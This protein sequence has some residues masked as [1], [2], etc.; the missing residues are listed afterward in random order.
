MTSLPVIIIL[1]VVVL[2]AGKLVAVY[3][4]LVGRR[5]GVDNAFAT[6][7]VQ[8][9]QRCD[10][11]PRVVASV[12]GY[13]Q[14]ERDVL[15]QLTALRARAVTEGLDPAARLALDAEMGGL[16]THV[17]ARAEAYPDLKAADTVLMLQRT[18]NEIEAQIAAARRAYNAAVTDYNTGRESFPVNLLAGAFGFSRRTLFEATA[19]ERLPSDTSAVTSVRP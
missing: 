3:N 18:L 6:I 1:V 8:L 15:E 14:Y 13:M 2:A 16:L 19:D 7:D 4:R 11:V 12:K 9:K 10:L 5:N 17:F